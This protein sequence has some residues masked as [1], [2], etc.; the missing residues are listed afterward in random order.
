ME[1]RFLVLLLVAAVAIVLGISIVSKQS[2]DPLMQ[3]LLEQQAEILRN[4]N[5]LQT[6]LSGNSIP[7]IN[8]A[9]D[10]SSLK[11]QLLEQRIATLEAQWKGLQKILD[12]VKAGDVQQQGPPQEDFSKVYDI[13]IDHSPIIGSKDAPVT[14]VEFLDFQCPFCARFHPP[15]V[16][17]LKAYPKEVR[18]I[19]K[20]FPLPF[21]PQARPAA[22][23]AL[24]ANE[25]GKYEEMVD[26][27]L[28]DNTNLSDDKFKELAKK[29]GLNVDKFMKDYKDKDAQ[30]EEYLNKDAALVNEVQ[31]RGTPTF[32][33]NGRKTMARDFAGFKKEIDEVLAGK[34]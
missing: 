3:A 2:K 21:H 34:K 26:A 18:Y 14:I 1:N 30:W 19:I 23:A 10:T 12:D 31:V 24:A 8:M 28:E 17:V 9:G 22:K 11:Q 4:Q 15:I 16:E 20:D 25:Q 7:N 5:Q 29:I 6:K 33:L 13:P 27:I 32:F